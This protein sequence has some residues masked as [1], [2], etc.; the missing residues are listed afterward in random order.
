MSLD[1]QSPRTTLRR[2]PER[3]A[4]DRATVDPI[5]DEALVCH[6]GFV[7][8]QSQPYVIPT[9]HVRIGDQLY[10]HGSPLSTLLRHA[11]GGHD[12]CL[13]ITLVDG[14][15]LARSAFHHSINFRSVVVLGRAIEVSDLDTKRAVLHA[16]VEKLEPGRS[17]GCRPPTD[18]ELRA[19]SVLAL[20]L[21][22]A[23]AKVRQ[24]GPIDDADDLALPHWVGVIP[25]ALRRGEPIGG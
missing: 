15:V 24:G 4:Y 13:T 21:T 23:S 10:I 3:G 11:K 18:K 16:L 12:L 8:D 17:A 22:E 9:T 20:A 6:V 2:H 5:V 19:T 14:L 1:L 7:G 25:M